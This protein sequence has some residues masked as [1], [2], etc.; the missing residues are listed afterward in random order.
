M[1]RHSAQRSVGWL[2]VGRLVV[3]VVGL[4]VRSFAG[5]CLRVCVHVCVCV[6]I[7]Y[8]FV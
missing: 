2:L 8:M 1:G 7:V 6:V 4:F 3:L 5:W